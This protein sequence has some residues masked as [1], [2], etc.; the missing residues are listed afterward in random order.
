MKYGFVDCPAATCPT[1]SRAKVVSVSKSPGAV[2]PATAFPG[3]L[4]VNF[5]Y[6]FQSGCPRP[7]DCVTPTAR[8]LNEA[9]VGG[10]PA[11][12]MR[13]TKVWQGFVDSRMEG[14]PDRPFTPQDM[15][16]KVVV[17]TVGREAKLYV[18]TSN[19][20]VPD[21]GSGRKWQAGT[22]V[23][24]SPDDGLYRLYQRELRSI[25][26]DGDMSQFRLGA[27]NAV[28]NSYFDPSV[29]PTS[30]PVTESGI[31]AFVFP[32]NTSAPAARP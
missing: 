30:L 18:A 25:A 13:V 28:G 29:D 7:G 4:S 14:N 24:T 2:P 9:I 1:F 23:D 31:A 3:R 11:Y 22:I 8:Y 20:D 5:H 26:E 12:T 6:Q 19:L 27:A 10:D 21:K 17:M 32:L 15:H 16:L